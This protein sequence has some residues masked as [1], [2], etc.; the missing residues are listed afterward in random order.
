MFKI[1]L[2]FLV[3]LIVS[4]PIYAQK[5]ITGAL[6]YKFGEIPPKEKIQNDLGDHCYVVIPSKKFRTFNMY[7]VNVTPITGKIYAVMLGYRT[8]EKDGEKEFRAALA[9]LENIYGKFKQVVD[10][11]LR[12]NYMYASGKQSIT[13]NYGRP[14]YDL[15]AVT[16]IYVDQDLYNQAQEEKRKQQI[17][18]TDASML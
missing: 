13:I 8:T 7:C 12:I 16:I 6:G 5:P 1:T 3:G 10:R 11:P 9:I 14:N 18:Q 2:I 17:K 4:L 15:E